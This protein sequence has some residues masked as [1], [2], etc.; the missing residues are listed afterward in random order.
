MA[1]LFVF[2]LLLFFACEKGDGRREKGEERRI[3][4][5]L[6]CLYLRTVFVAR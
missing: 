6:L 4:G 2:L 5:V 1:G 3:I